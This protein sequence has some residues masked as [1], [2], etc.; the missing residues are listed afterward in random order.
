MRTL[1][2]LIG[3]SFIFMGNAQCDIR[4]ENKH[5]CSPETGVTLG[6]ANTYSTGVLPF[7]YSWEID[8]IYVGSSIFPY[9]YASNILNDT[10]LANPSLVYNS[11]GDSMVF[12]VTL[13]DASG[14]QDTDTMLLTT[15]VFTLNCSEF[16]Y[17]INPGDSVFLN[18]SPN[19][20][21]GYGSITYDWDPSVGLSDTN[22]VQGFWA[23]PQV[24]TF[25]TA[26]VTDSKACS[27]SNGVFYRVYVNEASID[28]IEN[29]SNVNGYSIEQNVPNPFTDKTSI[30]F[31]LAPGVETATLSIFNLNGAFVKDYTLEGNSGEIE[32]LASEIGKGMYIY[33]LNKNG[34]EIIAKR[35]MIK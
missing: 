24:T 16:N 10:T 26:T 3:V 7:Q 8:P 19:I 14:C 2:L 28:E 21:G 5:R 12:Y 33:S 29:S 34:Q 22:L 9:F 31:Q 35:M 13:T 32:I 30:R 23:F 6:G 27:L 11:I 1:L 15:S 20:G 4:V 17:W 25:Y 18:E